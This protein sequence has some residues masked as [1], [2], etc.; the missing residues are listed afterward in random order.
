MMEQ[1][2]V[3]IKPDGVQRKLVGRIIQRFEDRNLTIKKMYQTVLD[4]PLVRKHYDHLKERNFFL[5]II[6]YMTSGSVI[7]ILLEGERVIEIARKMIGKTDALLAAPGTIRGDFAL[8]KSE[9]II[10]ASD[11]IEAAQ[12]EIERFFNSSIN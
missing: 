8:N 7:V 11:S 1:T 9:N 6:N 4:E 10:H 12:L 2:L 3:I 5:D